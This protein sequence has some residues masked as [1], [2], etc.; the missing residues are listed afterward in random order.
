[1]KS[2][3]ISGQWQSQSP[4]VGRLANG[5][6]TALLSLFFP[7]ALRLACSLRALK[8]NHP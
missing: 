6:L 8:A 1:M 5:L 2:D 4:A 3:L 7:F